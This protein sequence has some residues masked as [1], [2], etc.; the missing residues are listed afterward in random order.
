MSYFRNVHSLRHYVFLA[1]PL[2]L[3][4]VPS[5]GQAGCSRDDVDHYLEKG[6]TPSQV[7]AICG[8]P[9]APTVPTA[10]PSEF[11][12]SD[13]PSHPQQPIAPQPVAKQPKQPT[14][15]QPVV[16]P[17]SQFSIQLS[18]AQPSP[19]DQNFLID[20]INGYDTLL[21]EDTLA[22]T[23][24]RCYD[25]GEEDLFGFSPELCPEI[26]YTLNLNGMTFVDAG[27]K[28]LVFGP[29][30]IRLNG[31]VQRDI[32]TDLRDVQPD[33]K[34]LLVKAIDTGNDVVLPL[35]Q[36]TPLGRAE[37]ELRKILR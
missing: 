21:T 5:N 6:F 3:S 11:Q 7:T 18:S 36:G 23:M 22:F 34:E 17:P 33:L 12:K 31:Q 24:K 10:V 1:L 16:E 26:R 29:P 9:A 19:P 27:N 20:V 14:V 30:E 13:P 35:Q 28:Y 4:L 25:L 37:K 8:A 32:L 15:R 2:A